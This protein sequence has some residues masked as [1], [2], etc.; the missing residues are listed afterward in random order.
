MVSSGTQL[1]T[2]PLSIRWTLRYVEWATLVL[3]SLDR[4]LVSLFIP[5]E[6]RFL[7]IIVILG[8]FALLSLVFPIDRPYW[9]RVIYIFWEIFLISSALLVNLVLAALLFPI[10]IVK[11]CFLLNRRGVA[12]TVITAGIGYILPT[13]WWLHK[14]QSQDIPMPKT[15]PFPNL[16]ILDGGM[17]F[18]QASVFAV[19]LS[20]TVIA[21]QKSRQKAE[22]LTQQVETLAAS[23]ERSRIAR[24]IHDSLG[25]TLTTLDVQL[26]LAQKLRQREPNQAHQAIDTAK[27]LASQSL[28]EVRRAIQTMRQSSFNL[29]EALGVLVE[30]VQQTQ[31]FAIHLRLNLPQL[32]L[33]TSHQL[34]CIVQEGLTNIKKHAQ[35]SYVS[36]WSQ[37][38]RDGIHLELTDDGQGFD[39]QSP[40]SGFGL[41]G[42]QERVQSVGGQL[43]IESFPG[44]GTR[45]RV[46]LPR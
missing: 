24:E 31:P 28:M 23:L 17:F 6:T 3:I 16:I 25:H 12:L 36:L 38:T 41:L 1:G 21:E 14:I 42:M 44:Q 10:V 45:I 20:F 9:Q 5:L 15:P 11:S 32:P 37:Y 26:E 7:L 19:L 46:T 2:T 40:R 33:Q 43:E 18:L 39:L 35:A 8:A 29:N 34:Y 22:A 4:A 30:Q 27:Y 13:I